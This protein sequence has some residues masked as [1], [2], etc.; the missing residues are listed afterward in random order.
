MAEDR[1]I[2]I[3]ACAVFKEVIPQYIRETSTQVVFIEYGLHLT[4]RKLSAAIQEQIDALTEPRFVLIGYGLC[5]NGLL[6]LKS[7]SHTLILP[8]VNDCVALH[9]GSQADYLAAFQAEPATYYL[10]PGWLECGGEPMSEHEKCRDRFGPEKADLISDAL[11]GHYRR[12]CL[13]AFTPEDLARWRPRALQ[14]AEFCRERWGWQYQERVGSD[15]LIRR[16]LDA[17]SKAAEAGE[18]QGSRDFVVIDP[19]GEV[20]QEMY[21]PAL[22]VQ[23]EAEKCTTCTIK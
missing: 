23:E 9:L 6:G 7:R 22:S 13:I 14:V 20:R 12:T 18:S 19:G 8:R 16:L 3:I 1:Q 5:G 15:A 17:G 21:M 2:L 4:P 11:Y 10:T